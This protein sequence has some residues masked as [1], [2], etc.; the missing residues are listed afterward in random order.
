MIKPLCKLA[1]LAGLPCVVVQE[2]A[3]RLPKK[4]HVA[5]RVIALHCFVEVRVE[6][7]LLHV[8]LF[9]EVNEALSGGIIGI[10]E[11]LQQIEHKISR[12]VL[13]IPLIQVRF[14][15]RLLDHTGAALRATDDSLGAHPPALCRE[16]DALARAL[17]DVARSVADEGYA[18][19]HTAG[20]R[21]L[22]NGM[23]LHA[24]DLAS[25]NARRCP[26]TDALLVLLDSLL[27]NDSAGANRHVVILGEHPGVEIWRDILAHVHLGALLVVVHLVFGYAHALLE[28]NRVLVLPG[29]YHLG[30]AAVG[31]VTTDDDIDLEGALFACAS[32]ALLVSEVI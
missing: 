30:D 8:F 1:H 9:A 4:L 23:R 3:E 22:W 5:N 19:A 26:V 12:P 14:K 6:G 28:S 24:D 16:V 21:V 27:V 20:P 15:I 11:L 18:V 17:G 2:G 13:A 10:E 25:Y 32:I 29:L 31:A 7:D